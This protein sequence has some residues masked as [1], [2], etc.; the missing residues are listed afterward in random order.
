VLGLSSGSG[1]SIIASNAANGLE[2]WLGMGSYSFRTI[3]ARSCG[4]PG[5]SNAL[6]PPEAI[7]YATHPSAQTSAA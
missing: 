2:K 4:H 3:F 7:S 6:A 5:A 1:A